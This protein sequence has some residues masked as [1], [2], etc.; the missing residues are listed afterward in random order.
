[1]MKRIKWQMILA[2]VAALVFLCA[3]A[4]AESA[5]GSLEITIKKND[6]VPFDMTKVRLALYRVGSLE[7]NTWR[8]DSPF[9]GVK[10]IGVKGT[11]EIENALQDIQKLIDA[12]NVQPIAREYARANG[13]IL[14]RNL[15]RGIYY[16]HAIE[17]PDT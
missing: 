14:F 3:F 9:D 6:S 2:L 13:T 16:G 11:A 10:L 17:T 4:A 15:Q 7:N 1:M 8:M 12:N 5:T